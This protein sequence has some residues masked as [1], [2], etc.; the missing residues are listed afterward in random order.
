MDSTI[1]G[2][3]ASKTFFIRP[4]LPRIGA[5]QRIID[6]EVTV[7]NPRSHNVLMSLL[8]VVS[9]GALGLVDMNPKNKMDTY[10]VVV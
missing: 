3:F 2:E 1:C 7:P 8:N 10:A 6:A 9:V 5:F 4:G